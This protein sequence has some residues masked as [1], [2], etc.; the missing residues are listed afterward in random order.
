MALKRY[1]VRVPAAPPLFPYRTISH[2]VLF[3]HS[4]M[5]IIYLE[6]NSFTHVMT[7]Y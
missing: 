3:V 1:G 2:G 6:G 7:L 5:V 4:N